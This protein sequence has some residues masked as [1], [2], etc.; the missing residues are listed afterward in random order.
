[1]GAVKVSS[2]AV[3]MAVSAF[4]ISPSTGIGSALAGLDWHDSCKYSSA[5]NESFLNKENNFNP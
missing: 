5:V 3:S 4:R 1:M 2:L